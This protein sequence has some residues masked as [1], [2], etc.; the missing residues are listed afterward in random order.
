M[1]CFCVP[2]NVP[3]LRSPRPRV[4]PVGNGVWLIGTCFEASPPSF[5]WRAPSPQIVSFACFFV[6]LLFGV[7]SLVS[8]PN[9]QIVFFV[10][11]FPFWFLC[12]VSS[13]FVSFPNPQ[14]CGRSQTESFDGPGWPVQ[15]GYNGATMSLTGVTTSITSV[16]GLI[17]NYPLI[18]VHV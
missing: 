15:R 7:F 16:V 8:F 14:N 4:T 2:L 9:P 5:P 1:E 13:L 12:L 18:C 17:P 10:C 6:C 11:F 3:T